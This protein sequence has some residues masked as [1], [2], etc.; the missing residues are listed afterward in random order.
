[1]RIAVEK[2][3]FFPIQNWQATMGVFVSSIKPYG[4]NMEN[5]LVVSS[6]A[7]GDLVLIAK[8]AIILSLPSASL[9]PPVSLTTT[10]W[11]FGA[12][13]MGFLAYCKRSNAI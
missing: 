10:V 3:G 1:M 9:I 6:N 2:T 4:D 13:L 11:L 5:I 8:K 12:A 7:F